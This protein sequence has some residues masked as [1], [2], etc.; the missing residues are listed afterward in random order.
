[1]ESV[2][3]HLLVSGSVPGVDCTSDKNT[4]RVSSLSLPETVN[5][6]NSS[7]NLVLV[8]N[9]GIIFLE[10]LGLSILHLSGNDPRFVD[11][12]GLIHELSSTTNRL[13]IG[14]LVISLCSLGNSQFIEN[15]L[16]L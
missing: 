13:I 15:V 14:R 4:F 6:T 7:D 12:G 8:L 10:F 5:I 11:T 3:I 9:M 2:E 1:M 16:L